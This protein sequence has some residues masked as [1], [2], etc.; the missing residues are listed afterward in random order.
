MENCIFCKIIKGEI[1]AEKIYE[2]EICFAF[3]DVNP[4]NLGHTL[5]IPK[6]H[7]ENIYELPDDLLPKMSLVLKKLMIAVKKGVGADG[8]NLG[9]NNGEAAGQLVFHAHF[10][11][12]PRYTNDGHVHWKGTPHT[13][14]E[15]KLTAEKIKENI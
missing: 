4:V 15:N 7:Y 9:M 3:L 1:P 13:P 10:H 12:M 14:E 5:L 8:M 6:K 2:D 11:L